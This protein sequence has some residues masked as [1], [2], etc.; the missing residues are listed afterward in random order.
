MEVQERTVLFPA[1]LT[2]SNYEGNAVVM[3]ARTM[4][5]LLQAALR[6]KLR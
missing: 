3:D 5:E 1:V 6:Q 4:A 2:L